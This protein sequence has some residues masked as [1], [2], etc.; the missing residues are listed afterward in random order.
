MICY[1]IISYF[2]ENRTWHVI[3]IVYFGDNIHE[4]S[5]PI[6]WEKYF[7]F[8]IYRLLIFLFSQ[9]VLKANFTKGARE[10]QASAQLEIRSWLSSLLAI[11]QLQTAVSRRQS[12][13]NCL[14]FSETYV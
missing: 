14:I 2:P 8:S 5:Y 10:T 9:R 13:N 12:S 3:Q 1:I 11:N 7:F 6:S 4:M